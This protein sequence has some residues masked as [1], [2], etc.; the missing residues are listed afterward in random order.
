MEKNNEE[1]TEYK[2][3]K[4]EKLKVVKYKIERFFGKNIIFFGIVLC[5]VLLKLTGAINDL[6]Q[7]QVQLK[8][9]FADFKNSY[10][11]ITDSGL[12]NG[13]PR[14]FINPAE[15]ENEVAELLKV[16]LVDRATVSKGFT[17]SKITA[18]S[19]ILDSSSDLQSFL[20][21][22]ILVQRGEDGDIQNKAK[23]GY[24]YFQAYLSSIQ[25]L[26]RGIKENGLSMELPHY[27]KVVDKKINLYEFKDNQFSIDVSYR[28]STNTYIGKDNTGNPIWKAKEATSRIM[29]SGYFDIKTQNIG[30]NYEPKNG[31]KGDNLKGTNYNGLHFT[32]LKVMFGI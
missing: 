18:S 21:N 15:K 30:I 20:Y 19:E 28:T 10:I 32:E 8:S 25:E 22:Y 6:T 13:L 16:L 2:E 29:A 5:F 7:S 26:F 23:K 1:K 31:V 24:G 14:T 4:Y 12:M 11:S 27:L 3:P 9:E 17:L